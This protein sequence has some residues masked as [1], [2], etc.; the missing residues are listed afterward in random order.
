MTSE[1]ND[2]ART[3]ALLWGERERPNRGPKPGL[4]VDAIVRTAMTIA[5][6]EG[7]DALSM[8][9]VAEELGVGTM[10]LYTYVPA[11]AELFELMIEAAIGEDIQ[12]PDPARWRAWLERYA[13]DSLAGYRRHPWL[14][15]VPM[16]RGLIGP[17]QTAALESFLRTLSGTGLDGGM[18]MA[19][20]QLIDGYVRGMAQ[21]ALSD[22][23]HEQASGMSD[24][25]W[26]QEAGPLYDRYIDADRFPTLVSVYGS[27]NQDSWVDAFE[28]GLQRVLDGI[29]A[30][31]E[32]ARAR[33][34]E[35][36]ASP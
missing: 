33:R 29:E 31:V 11:K 8:R 23:E 19:V 25:Q 32:P 15:R 34:A 9:R 22:R 2:L 16:S 30:I 26:W 27:T 6:A 24:E 10:S 14:L 1:K 20:V 18:Q 7:F 36:P 21:T 3:M 4:S 12:A 5:D 28:F 17:N 35:H 13:R